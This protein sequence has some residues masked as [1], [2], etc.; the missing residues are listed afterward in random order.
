MNQEQLEAKINVMQKSEFL[1]D[2]HQFILDKKMA[3]FIKEMNDEF[4][5]N[6]G[7][8]LEEDGIEFVVQFMK[9]SWMLAN[10]VYEEE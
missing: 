5:Y 10:A 1:Q 4:G 9:L 7:E 3:V 8:P 2:Y 6:D